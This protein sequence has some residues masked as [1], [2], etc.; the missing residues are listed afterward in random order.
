M[1]SELEVW[2]LALNALVALV[3]LGLVPWAQSIRKAIKEL[4][5]EV[6]QMGI[7]HATLS[8]TVANLKWMDDFAAETRRKH[9]ELMEKQHRLELEIR[10]LRKLQD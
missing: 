3:A 7:G 4:T 10:D 1:E 5:D 9:D 8:T 2:N 6:H